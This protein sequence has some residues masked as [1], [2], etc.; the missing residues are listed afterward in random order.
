MKISRERL[1]QIIK[2]ELEALNE[3]HERGH[4]TEPL[5][6]PKKKKKPELGSGEVATDVRRRDGG[7]M[8]L[9]QR[10]AMDQRPKTQAARAAAAA[11]LKKQGGEIYQGLKNIFTG[12][13][14]A[15]ASDVGMASYDT[16]QPDQSTADIAPFVDPEIGDVPGRSATQ[17]TFDP[18]REYAKQTPTDPKKQKVAKTTRRRSG[19]GGNLAAAKKEMRAARAAMKQ[20][21][22]DK[23][24]SSVYDLKKSNSARRRF[25][26]AYTALKRAKA[27]GGGSSRRM[28]AKSATPAAAEAPKTVAQ[29]RAQSPKSVAPLR[30]DE[31]KA[32]S[33]DQA[34]YDQEIERQRQTKEIEARRRAAARKKKRQ[35][36]LT[37]LSPGDLKRFYKARRERAVDLQFSGLS[38][39]RSK[40]IAAKQAL[41][42]L[43]RAGSGGFATALFDTPLY[44]ADAGGSGKKQPAGSERMVAKKKKRRDSKTRTPAQQ[45]RR[46]KFL[47][48]VGA[49]GMN[50]A[51]KKGKLKQ[52]IKE[53]LSAVLNETEAPE[54]YIATI[55]TYLMKT[56][57]TLATVEQAEEIVRKMSDDEIAKLYP[58][59]QNYFS[60]QGGGSP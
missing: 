54:S 32:G 47:K 38:P 33:G 3:Y 34:G 27:G 51:T 30:P 23:G 59:A 8:T 60:K 21:L 35:D 16:S 18:E 5:K 14:G 13:T 49:S 42:A 44:G 20:E 45:R 29:A 41:D 39:E 22:K 53:E 19:G 31:P 57:E 9:A 37:S 15:R 6:Q 12:Q 10:Q 58:K 56:E 2:E 11:D 46:D 48:K 26:R 7:T 17:T 36:L 24:V 43:E 28:M 40:K 50:E 4:T 55:A 25:A 52:I 1:K